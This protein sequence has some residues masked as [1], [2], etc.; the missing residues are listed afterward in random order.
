[1]D[2]TDQQRALS[3]PCQPSR[4]APVLYVMLRYVAF[5]LGTFASVAEVVLFFYLIS[6]WPYEFTSPRIQGLF[7]HL[8]ELS[9]LVLAPFVPFY[10]VAC[11]WK[12]SKWLG[13]SAWSDASPAELVAAER[14]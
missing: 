14:Q 1:M 11:G 9:L 8:L 6:I 3:S 7:D 2:E 12:T 5:M 4:T 13:S 10:A